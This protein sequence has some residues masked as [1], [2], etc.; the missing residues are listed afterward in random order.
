MKN[1]ITIAIILLGLVVNAQDKDFYFMNFLNK[2]YY[3]IAE[4]ELNTPNLS[5]VQYDN[6]PRDPSKKAIEGEETKFSIFNYKHNRNMTL[7]YEAMLMT[8][9]YYSAVY[10]VDVNFEEDST[11]YEEL[12][13]MLDAQITLIR[14]NTDKSKFYGDNSWKGTFDGENVYIYTYPEKDG[15]FT[16]RFLNDLFME[17]VGNLSHRYQYGGYTWKRKEKKRL[18]HEKILNIEKKRVAEQSARLAKIKERR[19][20]REEAEKK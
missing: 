14:V 9:S 18:Y 3:E 1:L 7:T 13:V 17:S 16:V 11:F 20:A 5:Y 4:G 19:I 8:N 2:T 10:R 15:S 12:I 6:F